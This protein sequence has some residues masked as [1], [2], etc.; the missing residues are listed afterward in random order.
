[1]PPTAYNEDPGRL[2]SEKSVV[3]KELQWMLHT[4]APPLVAEIGT[5]LQTGITC[6]TPT[7]PD[8]S[9]AVRAAGSATLAITSANSDLLKGFVTVDGTAVV[10]GELN[11][12]L[13]HYNR[14]NAFKAVINPSNPPIL[15]Q[16]EEARNF[17]VLAYQEFRSHP[18]ATQ[19]QEALMQLLASISI[20]A[21]KAKAALTKIT[22]SSVFPNKECDG[23]W[24]SPE[25]P[26]DLV[27]E[28]HVIQASVVVSVFAL[29][30]HQPGIPLQIQSKI[31]SKFKN[32]KL[33]TY[34]GRPVEVLDQLTVESASPRLAT[35]ARSIDT[36]DGLCEDL[37]LKLQVLR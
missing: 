17:L 11:L 24:F 7:P 12:K 5:I 22:E 37:S 8:A 34:K 14:G 25:L 13:P 28:F 15:E 19:D 21:K 4:R 6:C 16:V 3:K 9:Q 1:M 35:L 23:K 29:N 26:D 32:M 36:V 20:L 33:D 30:Y 2:E 27:I 10:K 18:H 31:L